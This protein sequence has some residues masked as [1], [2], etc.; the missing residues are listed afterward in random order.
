MA[1]LT[2]EQVAQIRAAYQ[3]EGTINA[4]ARVTGFHHRTVR[5]YIEGEPAPT[6]AAKPAPKKEDIP[7]Q[8]RRVLVLMLD[9]L[10]TPGT[11]EKM[12]GQQLAVA[13]GIIVDKHELLTGE[14]TVR[15]ESGSIDP[16]KLTPE[17]R[18]AAARIREKLAAEIS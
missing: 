1:E 6:T 5:K 8:M 16:G 3:A 11:I 10:L 12:N 4:A 7:P 13:M 14:P 18:E 17:E 9:H 2:A 15:T